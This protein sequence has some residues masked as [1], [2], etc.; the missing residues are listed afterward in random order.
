MNEWTRHR[1]QEL[2]ARNSKWETHSG[3][4]LAATNVIPYLLHERNQVVHNGV[5]LQPK[6]RY[7]TEISSHIL[8]VPCTSDST[9]RHGLYFRKI[10]WNHIQGREHAI[11]VLR[12]LLVTRLMRFGWL[13]LRILIRFWASLSFSRYA[14]AVESVMRNSSS[15]CC[16]WGSSSL[17]F[18][19]Q[20]DFARVRPFWRQLSHQTWNAYRSN[21]LNSVESWLSMQGKFPTTSLFLCI[22]C[23]RQCATDEDAEPVHWTYGRDYYITRN[24]H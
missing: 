20:L 16:T 23:W 7:A 18:A 11:D 3:L 12:G 14:S 21:K 15:A 6:S 2:A 19:F 24:S 17:Y 10:H 22:P 4:T 1:L 8:R 9:L 5:S 13:L